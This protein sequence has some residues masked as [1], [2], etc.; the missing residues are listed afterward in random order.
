MKKKTIYYCALCIGFIALILGF[1]LYFFYWEIAL[2]LTGLQ[3]KSPLIWHDMKITFPKGI[4]YQ[5]YTKNGK[6]DGIVLTYYRDPEDTAFIRTRDLNRETL[7]HNIKKKD[8]KILE[9][10][11]IIFKGYKGFSVTF[12]DDQGMYNNFIYFPFKKLIFG[13]TGR[14][15]NFDKYK[16]ILNDIEFKESEETE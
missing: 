13:Y 16:K 15:D 14:R 8:G 1:G 2:P 3:T 6:D 7:L 11:D 9:V 10:E 4:T 12:I 5:T